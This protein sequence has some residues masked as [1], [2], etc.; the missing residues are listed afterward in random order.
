MIINPN[1]NPY[2]NNITTSPTPIIT[3]Q[4]QA[5]PTQQG[6]G[7]ARKRKKRNMDKGKENG[8]SLLEFLRS[9]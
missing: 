7:E 6:E 4:K 2:Y 3:P 8:M 1:H 5:P 9:K